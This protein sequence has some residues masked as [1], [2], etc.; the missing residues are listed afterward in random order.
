MNNYIIKYNEL[1]AEDYIYLWNS[2]WTDTPTYE[3]VKLAMQN[4]LFRVSIYDKDKLIA[5]ARMIGDKGLDYYIKD[6]VV[7]PEYQSKGVGRILINEL[8]NY[9]ND[10]G[11]ADTKI[12]VELCAM[13]GVIDFYKKFGFDSNEAQ[14]L[15]M[16][17]DVN[18]DK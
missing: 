7:I 14:R 4:T 16:M 17:I 12:F 3:Q 5:M 1:S 10:N 11:I 15:K 2:V 8:L 9:I 18:H 13:P 6:V